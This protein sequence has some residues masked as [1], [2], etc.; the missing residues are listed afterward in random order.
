MLFTLYTSEIQE[1]IRSHNLECHVY[2]D[3]TQLYFHCA[4]DQLAIVTQRLLTCIKAIKNWMSSNRLRLNPD[5]TEFIW[6]GSAYN[7]KHVQLAPLV[8]S[9]IPIIPSTTVRDL[10]VY[11][12]STLSMRDQVAHCVQSC[13]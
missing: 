12:D 4:P 6:F 7:L 13:F 11:F 3:D 2:A 10:G 5:K 1:I 9:S 8:V